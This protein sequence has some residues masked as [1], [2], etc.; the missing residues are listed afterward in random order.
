MRK[1]CRQARGGLGQR[2]PRLRDPGASV[3]STAF[4]CR[5]RYP[6]GKSWPAI[7]HR[8]RCISDLA[9][10][11][12]RDGRFSGQQT[13]NRLRIARGNGKEITLFV[14]AN[15]G[16]ELPIGRQGKRETVGSFRTDGLDLV[17]GDVLNVK[18]DAVIGFGSRQ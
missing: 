16:N 11:T 13:G 2:T 6:T 18:P 1:P 7:R 5:W 8:D 14:G 12:P 3:A 10:G 9:I 17:G 4:G 15:G